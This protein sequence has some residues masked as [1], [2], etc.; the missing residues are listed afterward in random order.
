M[1]RKSALVVGG[2]ALT[3]SAFTSLEAD[4]DVAVFVHESFQAL[5]EELT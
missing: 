4:A 5:S 2:N 1:Q 3:V